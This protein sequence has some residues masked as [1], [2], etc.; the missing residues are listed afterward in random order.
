MSMET[1]SGN[2]AAETDRT[3]AGALLYR[4]SS[5]NSVCYQAGAA[6]MQNQA[7]PLMDHFAAEAPI[8]CNL[9]R[10]QQLIAET[11][12]EANLCYTCSSCA[13]ECP[14]NLHSNR[15]TP[16]KLVRMA[17][18]GLEQELIESPD[19]WNCIS[20][21]HCSQICPMTVT[22]SD[23]IAYLRREALKRKTV[24][25]GIVGRLRELHR[26]FHRIRWHI[27]SD[28]LKG[29]KPS[30]LEARWDTL[31]ETPIQTDS[32][33]VVYF[34]T[35][36]EQTRFREVSKNYLKVPTHLNFCHTCKECIVACP[37]A[38]E[39]S[40]FNPLRIFRMV[41]LGLEEEVLTSP[42]IWL[43]LGCQN[44]TNACSQ[45]VK[46]DLII[47][48]LQEMAQEK[49]YVRPAS[50]FQWRR[51]QKELYVSLFKRVETIWMQMIKT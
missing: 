16:M 26:Q 7:I 9:K 46:G 50:L 11:G 34:N 21:N 37:I 48:H 19:I 4:P 38:F 42:S 8:T 43:C 33:T 39:P 5:D 18:F 24:S 31:A 3:A 35:S 32:E 41:A 14:V 45:R 23:I 36:P 22:P 44:C 12:S 40:V 49:G 1:L 10:G 28:C 2:L 29:D 51:A 47:R 27:I 17:I 6:E 20:C 15:L 25:Y 30:Q 13:N